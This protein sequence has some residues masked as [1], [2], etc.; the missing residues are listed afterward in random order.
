MFD[1]IRSG[2]KAVTSAV[3]AV[4]DQVTLPHSSALRIPCVPQIYDG[5]GRVG[6][7]LNKAAKTIIRVRFF[8]T[9]LLCWTRARSERLSAVVEEYLLV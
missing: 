6:D 1:P 4:P 8:I 7:G 2:M 3:T 5:V 9:S